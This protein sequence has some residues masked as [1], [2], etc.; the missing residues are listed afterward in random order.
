MPIDDLGAEVPQGELA[1]PA[2]PETPPGNASPALTAE[3][4][5]AVMEE[6]V[7]SN[8]QEVLQLVQGLQGKFEQMAAAQ[9][10]PAIPDDPDD[11]AGKLLADGKTT[12]R[13]QMNEWGRDELAP[14]LGRK[15]E[16]DRDERVAAQA[17]RVDEKYGSGFFAEHIKP[18]LEGPQGNLAVYPIN[19]Q[20]D[21]TVINS[22]VNG[23]IGNM[24][25]DNE[26][27]PVLQEAM[28]KTAKAKAERDVRTPANMMG[29]GRVQGERSTKLSPE[30]LDAVEKF[31]AVV[32]SH[33]K[34]DEA[35]IK[36]AINRPNTLEAWR[37]AHPKGA[38]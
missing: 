14:I 17:T 38:Q 28:E 5:K 1:A 27:G 11:F 24:M 35:T 21:P 33:I 7:S 10:S 26:V 36:G 23:I 19:Q 12:I 18:R 4:L 3:D 9:A 13:E 15:F 22:A 31:S 30:M 29:P 6:A 25:M 8:N 16:I 32:P 2:T 34:L 37:A 20:S